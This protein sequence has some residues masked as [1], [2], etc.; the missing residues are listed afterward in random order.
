LNVALL[1]ATTADPDGNVTTEREALVLELR[2]AATAVHNAGGLVIV[3]V[4]RI[5]ER[6]SLSPRRVEI[7]GARSDCVVV[8]S[9]DHRWQTCAPPYS[10]LVHAV[11]ACGAAGRSSPGPA[12]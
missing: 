6:G 11:N 1:R 4:E 2:A 10:A 12:P 3:Q 8:A 9:P 7:P 5:A